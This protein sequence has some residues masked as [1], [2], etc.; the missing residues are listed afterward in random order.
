MLNL[1]ANIAGMFSILAAMLSKT[2]FALTLLRISQ[3]WMK[4]V[5]WVMIITLNVVM[6]VSALIQWV[7]CMPIK[8]SWD[9]GV[10]GTCWPNHI[11]VTYYQFTT[12]KA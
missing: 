1:V 12:C 11:V 6:G 9:F 2:S 8:K 3:P 10:E 4:K 7:H 5:I